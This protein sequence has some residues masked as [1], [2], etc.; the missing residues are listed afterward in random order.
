M[1]NRGTIQPEPACKFLEENPNE[2]QVTSSQRAQTHWQVT[3]KLHTLAK[4]LMR[5]PEKQRV[6][7][8][9]VLRG[10]EYQSS[11]LPIAKD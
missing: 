6:K 11:V 5:N 7:W 2:T 4:M 10:L 8:K 3:D 9:A 1:K